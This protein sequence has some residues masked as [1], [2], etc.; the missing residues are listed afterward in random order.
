MPLTRRIVQRGR[1]DGRLW[2]KR[3][4]ELALRMWGESEPAGQESRPAQ[5]TWVFVR[6][7]PLGY[8]LGRALARAK[9]N[10]R[11]GAI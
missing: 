1:P 3:L 9:A 2:G 7:P 8:N 4:R 6:A 10:P 5:R 11:P